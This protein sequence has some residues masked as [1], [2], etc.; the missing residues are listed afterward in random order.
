MFLINWLAWI[1]VGLDRNGQDTPLSTV[2]V[3]ILS[4]SDSLKARIE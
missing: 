3:A 1:E 4:Q 2:G